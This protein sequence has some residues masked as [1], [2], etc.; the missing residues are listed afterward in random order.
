M[1]RGEREPERAAARQKSLGFP[2]QQPALLSYLQRLYYRLWLDTH[3][4]N[5][6]DHQA[7]HAAQGE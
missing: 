2:R 7:S 5:H 6:A 3:C 4:A 1:A